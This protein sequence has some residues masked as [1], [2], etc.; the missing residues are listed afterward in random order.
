MLFA[1]PVWV[2]GAVFLQ[3]EIALLSCFPIVHVFLCVTLRLF[4]A[5]TQP[6]LK[7]DEEPSPHRYRNGVISQVGWRNR[8]Q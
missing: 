4:L 6:F 5:N 3:K 2:V 7:S 1:S 8:K